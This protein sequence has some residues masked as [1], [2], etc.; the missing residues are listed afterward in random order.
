MPPSY[1]LLSLVGVV[2][3]LAL[4]PRLGNWSVRLVLLLARSSPAVIEAVHQ[5]AF[6]DVLQ[7][8][9]VTPAILERELKATA[10][11]LERAPPHE[12]TR[13]WSHLQALESHRALLSQALAELRGHARSLTR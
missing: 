4:R 3:G 11:L 10:E 7:R 6:R 8:S 13:P 2:L 9:A 5:Q 1:L 12:R